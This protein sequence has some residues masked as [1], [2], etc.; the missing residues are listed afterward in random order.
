MALL[1]HCDSGA[2]SEALIP[3]DL[4]ADVHVPHD[5][6]I[7]Y[8]HREAA[9]SIQGFLTK[10]IHGAPANPVTNKSAIWTR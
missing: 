7:T 5:G 1:A 2:S 3:Q 4:L 10:R 8:V 6:S 9:N